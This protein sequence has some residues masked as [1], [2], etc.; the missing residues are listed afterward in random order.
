MK[1][2]IAIWT[3][4]MLLPCMVSAQPHLRHPEIYLGLH[5]G[6]AAS[7]V[8]FSPSI[9][10]MSPI[11]K[12]CNLGPTGGLVFRYAG[13]KYCG[14][15]LDVNYLECGWQEKNDDA[16]YNR[17]LRYIEVP[18]MMHLYFGKQSGRGFINVGPQIGYCFWDDGGKGE[19]IGKEKA[20]YQPID[21]RFDWGVA[22]GLGGYFRSRN[23]GIYEIEARFHYSLGN[24]F[25]NS[26]GSS[27]R[28][29][30]NP[31]ELSIC[32]GWMWEFKHKEHR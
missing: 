23:A 14:L 12:A 17:K 15:Q 6:V 2:R 30:S 19:Q 9:D 16:R 4:V 31:M 11:T 21:N 18:F 28:N 13:Q 26:S 32:L 22:A 25:S 27:F 1:W 8:Q 24:I 7:T 3:M 10:N 29:G 20:Q 5:G